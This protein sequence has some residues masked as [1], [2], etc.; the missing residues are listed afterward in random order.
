MNRT[1][2][3]QAL[4]KNHATR[5]RKCNSARAVI[6]KYGLKICRRCFKDSALELGFR[7]YD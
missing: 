6:K 7:K 2:K 1:D 4:K 3:V 5:C